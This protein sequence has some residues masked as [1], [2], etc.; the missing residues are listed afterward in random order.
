MPV[1]SRHQGFYS[2][3][4]TCKPGSFHKS[5]TGEIDL[6]FLTYPDFLSLSGVVRYLHY[7]NHGAAV[8]TADGID[9]GHGPREYRVDWIPRGHALLRRRSPAGAI[10]GKRAEYAGDMDLE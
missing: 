1:P 6:E 10:H 8:T 4:L 5:R 7:T 9:P 3:H 2:R